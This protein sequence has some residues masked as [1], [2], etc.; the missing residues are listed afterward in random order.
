M[1][2]NSC[3][4]V[5]LGLYRERSNLVGYIIVILFFKSRTLYR[6]RSNLVDY[7]IIILFFKSIEQPFFSPNI[8]LDYSYFSFLSPRCSNCHLSPLFC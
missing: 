6:E 5:L 2:E 1:L 3:I 4:E 7:I 8:A